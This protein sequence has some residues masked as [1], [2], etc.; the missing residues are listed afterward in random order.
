[1]AGFAVLLLKFGDYLAQ[2]EPAF[3]IEFLE[4]TISAREAAVRQSA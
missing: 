1:M 3:L 2:D 4:R